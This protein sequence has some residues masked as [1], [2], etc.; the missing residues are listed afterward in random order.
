MTRFFGILGFAKK[1]KKKTYRVTNVTKFKIVT[2]WHLEMSQNVT[3]C[4]TFSNLWYKATLTFHVC[5]R[6]WTTLRE[7]KDF[8]YSSGGPQPAMNTGTQ[9]W[10]LLTRR[11]HSLW[12]GRSRQ[13]M[14]SWGY[15]G[16]E[17]GKRKRIVCNQSN[18]KESN[19][20][21]FM[22]FDVIDDCIVQVWWCDW[23][24]SHRWRPI[25]RVLVRCGN[26]QNVFCASPFLDSNKSLHDVCCWQGWWRWLRED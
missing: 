23:E 3:K 26:V 20:C 4:H 9:I 5:I 1:T 18:Q 19:L 24:R 21:D 17:L 7:S 2:L 6:L 16:M 10:I 13:A 25:H 8:Y 15:S 11:R 14:K 12:R 22:W